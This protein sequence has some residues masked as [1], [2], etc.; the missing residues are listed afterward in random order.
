M[1]TLGGCS[2]GRMQAPGAARVAAV[3]TKCCTLFESCRSSAAWPVANT[4]ALLSTCLPVRDLVEHALSFGFWRSSS[5]DDALTTS[6]GPM[7]LSLAPQTG[8]VP[9]V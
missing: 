7:S 4:F 6:G 1:L 2:A 3:A 8:D 5:G 9:E